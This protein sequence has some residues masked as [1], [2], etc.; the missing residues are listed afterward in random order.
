[1]EEL[2]I[3]R[4]SKSNWS[5]PLHMVPKDTTDWRPC[6]DFRF[7]NRITKPDRYPIPHI[8]DFTQGL[9]GMTV[10][11]KIDLVRAFLQIPIHPDDV[12]KT[13][14]ITPFGLFELRINLRMPFGLRNAARTF[15][16]F[17]DEVLRGIQFVYAYLDDLLVA[18][19]DVDSH[20]T[21]LRE[22][23]SRL[24]DFGLTINPAKCQFGKSTL[25]FLG[26]Q[27]SSDG[28]KPVQ[29]RVE[30]IQ[31]FPLPTSYKS[32]RRFLGLLNYHHRFIPK[33]A[34]VMAP[35]NELLKTNNRFSPNFKWTPKATAAFE[36]SKQSLAKAVLLHYPRA[37]THLLL[38]VDASD[39]AIGAVLSQIDSVELVGRQNPQPLKNSSTYNERQSRQLDYIIQCTSDVRHVKGTDNIVADVLSRPQIAASQSKGTAI[40]SLDVTQLAFEQWRDPELKSILSGKTPFMNKDIAQWAKT[41]IHCQ[42]NKIQRHVK[43][44]LGSFSD[45]DER[46]QHV[47]IDI[48]TLKQAGPYRYL[49]TAVDRYTRWPEAYPLED[50]EAAT[51]ARAFLNGWIARFGVHLRKYI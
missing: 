13:A 3:V 16:R 33:A 39:E 25:D 49:L 30:S 34:Q 4:R 47:H 29:G 24:Q 38:S 20:K 31:Q 1:M 7:L 32:L 48:V 17:I 10:F 50:V 12:E 40:D 43:S 28:I 35:L 15:Q 37:K 36:A 41:C 44:P 5:S 8:Q 11:S 14:V 21:H 51:V 9:E 22:V 42:R 27:V 18:S 45:P 19:L 46:M 26:H 6:G 2:G 23:F